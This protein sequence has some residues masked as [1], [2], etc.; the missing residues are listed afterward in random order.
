MKE[1]L[2]I[3]IPLAKDRSWHFPA[4]ALGLFIFVGVIFW[5]GHNFQQPKDKLPANQQCL[6][7]NQV[8]KE[9]AK[10]FASQLAS[11]LDGVDAP[12]PDLSKVKDASL[13]CKATQDQVTVKVEAGK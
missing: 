6:Q 13:E 7:A 2:G 10:T 11:A 9:A 4:K 1:E 5:A 8:T 12:A 3:D